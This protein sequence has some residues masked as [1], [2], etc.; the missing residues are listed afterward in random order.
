MGETLKKM[1]LS[2]AVPKGLKPQECERGSVRNKPL[3]P[4]IPEK[5]KLQEAVESGT[6]TI[7]LMLPGKVELQVSIWTSGT[8]EQFV[9]HVQQAIS[10]IRQKGLKEAYN[11]LLK[12]KKECKMKLEE[13]TLNSEFSPKGQEM[14]HLNQAKKTDQYIRRFFWSGCYFWPC[15]SGVVNSGISGLDSVVFIGRVDLCCAFDYGLKVG[16]PGLSATAAY[17]GLAK[18]GAGER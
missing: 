11:R 10:A 16:L 8:Q 6:S 7:K 17:I 14:T 1:T 12:T 15:L 9:M 18:S 2:K 13:A 3:I 4:Y 5:D